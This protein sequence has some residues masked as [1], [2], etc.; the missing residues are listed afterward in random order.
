MTAGEF[1]RAV[2][3][4]SKPRGLSELNRTALAAAQMVADGVILT[5]LSFL[6]LALVLFLDRYQGVRVYLYLLPTLCA[7]ATLIF[8]LARSGVYDILNLHDRIGILTA[9]VKQLAQTMLLLTGFFFVLKISDTFSRAW[10]G[11][12][13]LTSMFALCG[14][15]L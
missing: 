5:T 13:T 15:A 8:G 2:R 7:T 14:F 6:S 9:T 10:L 11:I 1:A 4:R 3:N 12:W